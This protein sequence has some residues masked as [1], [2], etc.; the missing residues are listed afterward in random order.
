MAWSSAAW[1]LG[2]VRLISSASTTLAKTGPG[3]NRK[4]RFPVVRSSSM[5][6][7]PVMSPGMRSGVNCTRLKLSFSASATVWTI[8]VF[9]RPGTPIRRAWPPARMA[10]RMPSTTAS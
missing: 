10:V 8:R 2:G 4:A 5:I 9:A 7:V 1:V 3:T 6:S